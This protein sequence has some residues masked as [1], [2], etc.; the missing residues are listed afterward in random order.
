MKLIYKIM[1]MSL[2]FVGLS[3]D[4]DRDLENPNEVGVDTADPSLL[5]NT[6][7]TDFASFFAKVEGADQTTSN[8]ISMLMRMWAL[9]TG[10]DYQ[11]AY[12]PQDVDDYWVYAYQRTLINIDAMLPL[13]E[14]DN[15]TTHVA[16]GKIM[17][18]YIYMTLVDVFGDVP[19]SQA[20][21]ASEGILHPVADPGDQVYA[22][23][24]QLLDEA[25]AELAKTGADA[26]SGLTR[27]IFYGGNRTKWNKLANSLELKA[28]LNISALPAR[29]AEAKAKIEGLLA[30]S[31]G[32]IENDADEFVYQYGTSSVPET[33][34][35]PLYRDG[36]R[37]ALGDAGGWLGIHYLKQVY[38]GLGVQD[39]R[40]RYYFYRQVGSLKQALTIDPQSIDCINATAT[41]TLNK[42]THYETKGFIHCAFDPGWYGRDHGN[43]ESANP[44]G[45][46]MTVVGVYPA[47]GRLDTNPTGDA[48][49]PNYHGPTQLGQGANGAGILPIY[50][51]FFTDFMKA[52][53]VLRLGISGDAKEFMLSG[54][55]KSINRV[56]SFAS[57][58][59]QTLPAGLEPAAVTYTATLSGIYDISLDQLDV[60]INEYYKALWG[61]SIE[62]YNMYRRTSSPRNLQWLRDRA[63]GGTFPRSMIYP[64]HFSNLNSNG[65][66]KADLN[67]RVFWDGNPEVLK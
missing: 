21:R 62:A 6:I 16:A 26:G 52:E 9:S 13:A 40:W 44:D 37:P 29:Q 57:S 65:L 50:M 19:A 7:Q 42:P 53:A 1:G 18:A 55:N 39:P 14:E 61:N 23:A 60:V 27:D 3:C 63:D 28:W 45:S 24:I 43:S 64:A 5:M 11:T 48:G 32:L 10:D 46:I 35:H 12:F 30:L 41:A 8:G 51:S 2:L 66:K 17:K 54:V 47:G 56:R 67:V 36:Y 4:L 25:R 31:N 59:G 58:R 38:N 49:N 15:L 34:R 33:S 20:L 22:M